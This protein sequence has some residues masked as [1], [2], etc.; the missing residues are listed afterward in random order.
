[1][2]WNNG[3]DRTAA[4]AANELARFVHCTLRLQI[5]PQFVGIDVVGSLIDIDELR[6]RPCLRNRLGG[7]NKRVRNGYD[8]IARLYATRHNGEAQSIGPATDSDGKVGFTEARERLFKSLH[9]RATDEARGAECL[10]ENGSEFR[11]ELEMRRDKIKKR[12]AGNA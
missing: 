4:S 9:H 2:D 1:M 8:H 11:F 10:L 3:G 6:K 12:N 5:L 7:C